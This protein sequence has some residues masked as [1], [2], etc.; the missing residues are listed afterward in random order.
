MKISSDRYQYETE[1][2]LE[3]NKHLCRIDYV[4]IDTIYN[5]EVSNINAFRDISNFIK[6][7]LKHI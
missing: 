3:M 5:G 6:V 1:I 2:I 7:I 4:S